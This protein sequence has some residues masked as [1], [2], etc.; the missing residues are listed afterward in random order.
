MR[1]LLLLLPLLLACGPAVGQSV[2]SSRAT[3][4]E[5]VALERV[6]MKAD[7]ATYVP[8]QARKDGLA[9]VQAVD[10]SQ[11]FVQTKAGMLVALDAA[12]GKE[13]WKYKFPAGFAEGFSVA[14]N[15]RYVFSVNVAKLYCH[16][17]YNG[18]LEFDTDL[19]EAPSVGP[20]TDGNRLYVVFSSGK[21]ACYT[22]PAVYEETPAA[23]ERAKADLKAK[24][25]KIPNDVAS[26][27]PADEVAGRRPGRGMGNR[28]EVPPEQ[29]NVPKSYLDTTIAGVGST[30]PVWS[31]AG[32]Q[33]VTPPYSVGGL[34]KV[35]S[36]AMLPSVVQPYTMNPEFLAY[37]QLSPSVAA[38]PPSVA[39]LYQMS[40][41]QPP[42][43][44]PRRAWLAE[45][46]GQ[47]YSDPVFSPTF[48][49]PA[50]K[51]PE[52]VGGSVVV[53]PGT[54]AGLRTSVEGELWMAT[55]SRS[56]RSLSEGPESS[57][58]EGA[59]KLPAKPA[60]GAAGPFGFGKNGGYVFLPLSD[61]QVA[62]YST[63]GG[64]D[65]ST[66]VGGILNRV[67]LGATDGVYVGG[68]RTGTARINV[69]TGEVDWR[70]D[71]DI[72]RI[73]AVSDAHVFARDRKGTLYLYAKGKADPNT[74]LARPVGSL[75]AADFT[76]TTV[77]PTTDRVLLAADNGLVVCLRDASV[78]AA[79]PK[80][81]SAPPLNPVPPGGDMKPA[82]PKDPPKD[83]KP[84]DPPK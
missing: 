10:E 42:P 22:L 23:F 1:K 9:R 69:D 46:R 52:L 82:D 33:T 75:A 67:P 76:V 37:N 18:T 51:Q 62:A 63:S 5:T 54:Y 79:K 56:F 28:P 4:P 58:V 81:I 12:S 34:N 32:V 31:V 30:Q 2:N 25:A 55:D 26:Q 83:P 29:F 59:R 78:K 68:D 71:D 60:A 36:L 35:V 6:G 15:H 38:I 72:D 84:V 19:P 65:F 17:R 57:P 45:G 41:L 64:R 50:I 53:H 7:W 20:V 47:V 49:A 74:Q 61:G 80:R 43:F 66:N 11:V 13:Q 77:N 27:Q 16:H 44:S 8:V 14:V 24:G 40:N 39:R 70:T 73:V 21:V 48:A 3:P